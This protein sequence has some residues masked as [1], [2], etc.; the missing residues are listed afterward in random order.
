LMAESTLAVFPY[1][2]GESASGAL[3]TALGNGR[4]AVVTDVLGETVEE[5]G[6]GLV[7]PPEDPEALAAAIRRLL[8]DPGAL[9]R[10]FR[11][12]EAARR[13]L[14]WSA[15]AEAHERLYAGLLAEA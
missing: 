9:D 7:V 1:R 14:S 13:G 15:I 12:T 2:S 5:Y 11:G 8:D 4:P 3:A 10:A 6:A